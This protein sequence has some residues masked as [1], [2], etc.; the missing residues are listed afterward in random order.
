MVAVSQA[1]VAAVRVVREVRVDVI[2]DMDTAAVDHQAQERAVRVVPM[3]TA[4]V[5]AA[6]V[7]SQARD[8]MEDTAL[9]LILSRQREATEATVVVQVQASQ[10]RDLV[11]M[12]MAVEDQAVESLEKDLVD[13][14]VMAV[15][16]QAQGSQEKPLD[17]V[18]TVLDLI[19]RVQR[20][21][22]EDTDQARAVA[23]LVRDHLVDTDMAVDQAQVNLARADMVRASQERDMVT[24]DRPVTKPMME[25]M[26]EEI[27]VLEELIKF[28]PS[29]SYVIS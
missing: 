1:R 2:V 4:Q 19:Q 29:P 3:V 16:D 5:Q 17:M 23:N 20:E 6:A 11:D 22:T 14:V 21:A 28:L 24:A 15:E 25:R 8:H 12:D 9:V 18:V 13:T 7:E 26:Y 10:V 27:F